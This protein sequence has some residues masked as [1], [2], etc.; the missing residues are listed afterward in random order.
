MAAAG[1][2]GLLSG[3]C[4]IDEQPDGGG[5][6]DVLRLCLDGLP[7]LDGEGDAGGAAVVPEEVALAM[8]AARRREAADG[9][10][11]HS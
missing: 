6:A 5:E 9:L 3:E 10:S 1:H 11:G 2:V 8:A 4:A 7:L